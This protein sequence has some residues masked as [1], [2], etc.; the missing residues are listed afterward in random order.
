[1]LKILNYFLKFSFNKKQE[2]IFFFYF[3]REIIYSFLVS[4]QIISANDYFDLIFFGKMINYEKDNPI[5]T[6]RGK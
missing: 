5:F 1:L 3:E 6:E 2:S 4:K